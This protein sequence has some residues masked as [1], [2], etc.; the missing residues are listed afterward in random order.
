MLPFC[1]YD[2]QL[3]PF[4]RMVFA[5]SIRIIHHQ[6]IAWYNYLTILIEGISVNYYIELKKMQKDD[7][8]INWSSSTL[9]EPSKM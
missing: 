2:G 5:L 9:V 1:L 6:W 7:N 3:H 4:S 8:N